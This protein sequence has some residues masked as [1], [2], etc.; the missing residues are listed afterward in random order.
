MTCG[1][2][3]TWLFLCSGSLIELWRLA[4]RVTDIAYYYNQCPKSQEKIVS[5]QFGVRS[6]PFESSQSDH[7][8]T[9]E[10]LQ[11][12]RPRR[13]SN[14]AECSWLLELFELSRL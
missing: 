4:R 5:F 10:L 8:Q 12:F 9:W 11:C 13:L 2:E 7:Q 3:A 1:V 6:G 14:A